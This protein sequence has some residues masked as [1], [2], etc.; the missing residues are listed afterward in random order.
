MYCVLVMLLS[1]ERLVPHQGL[2]ERLELENIDFQGA[3]TE[4]AHSEY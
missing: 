3:M 1:E 2:C 4:H